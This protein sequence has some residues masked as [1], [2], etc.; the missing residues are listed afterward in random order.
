MSR[1]SSLTKEKKKG[2]LLLVV[3]FILMMV[4]CG[5]LGYFLG[6]GDLINPKEDNVENDVNNSNDKEKD[7]NE[8]KDVEVD[9]F[10][11]SL[12]DKMTTADICNMASYDYY[13]DKKVT[14]DDLS[15][16][17]A[18]LIMLNALHKKG[19]VFSQYSTF[20]SEMAHDIVKSILGKDYNYIDE[21]IS[22]CPPVNYSSEEKTYSFGYSACGG[23]CGPHT[24]SKLLSAK[25]NDD[26]IE[27]TIGVV[28]GP[29]GNDLKMYSDYDRTNV[30]VEDGNVT[31]SDYEKGAKYKMTFKREDGNYVFVS[32]EPIK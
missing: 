12:L 7:N 5:G 26:I 1:E 20:S 27:L 13:T 15:N 22:F 29:K 31:D 14:V 18:Q 9:E 32:S 2:R 4:L 11:I 24:V 23:S 21:S 3:C 25:K 6:A 30:I 8:L 16:R 19:I 28:F 17:H 10:M